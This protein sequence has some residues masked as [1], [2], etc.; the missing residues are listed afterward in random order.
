[1]KHI[2]LAGSW[3]LSKNSE[4]KFIKANLPGDNLSA[5]YQAGEVDDP[6]HGKNELDLQWLGSTKW[7]YSRT[8]TVK[9]STLDELSIMLNIENIDTFA[10]IFINEKKVGS[11][12]NAFRRYRFEVKK[13]L[14]IGENQIKIVFAPHEQILAKKAKK[15]PRP[16]PHTINKVQSMHR[17]L[18]RKTQCHAGWDWGP[19]LMVSGVYGDIHLD[20]TSISRISHVTTTQKFKGDDCIVT[21]TNEVEAVV[22][23]KVPLSIELGGKSVSKMVNL[24][25]GLNNISEKIVIK[26][27]ERWWP[28]GYGKQKLY[29]LLVT[30]AED[31]IEKKL[32]L[33][34]LEIITNEDNKG[35]SLVF[36]VN[37]VDIFCKG[38]NW[39]PVDAMPE[40]Q[41]REVYD[42]LLSSAAEVHMNM[43]RVWGGGQY[44]RDDFYQLC[45]EK[46]LLVWQ[47]FMFACAPYPGDKEFFDNVKIEAEYQIKRLQ[48]HASLAFWCGNNECFV[49][50]P[51]ENRNNYL[52]DYDRLY[53]RLLRNSVESIDPTHKYWPS[54]PSGGRDDYSD[55]FHDDSRGDMHYWGV[56]H[57]GKNFDAYYDIIPRFCSEFGYQSFPS[58]EVIE[59]YADKDQWNVTAPVM[60]HHQKNA[61][62]NSKITEMF[63]RYFRIPQG[64]DNFVYLSQVQQGIAIRTAIEYWRSL[65]PTCMGT[66]YW[67][68]NDN[69]PVCSWSSLNYGGKWKILHYMAKRF[70]APLMLTVFQRKYGAPVE[71]W[72][73]N[74]LLEA[75]TGTMT[76]KVCDFT[77]KVLKKESR[78]IKLAK[79]S[80]KQIINYKVNK[81]TDREDETF[82][83]VELKVGK[84]TIRNDLFFTEYKRCNLPEAKIKTIIGEKEDKLT[85]TLEASA[86]AFF[87]TLDAK[88]LNGE[89]NDNAITLMPGEKRTLIFNS[90]ESISRIALKETLVLRHLRE[91]Y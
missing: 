90:R 21:V 33:R 35:M 76:M 48:N 81:L 8:F 46:G 53:E 15:L 41:T 52:V 39:I 5:L 17:N 71:I 58:P 14:R 29:P 45:D 30:I 1:M 9:D 34:E 78:N 44:E 64:F 51:Q 55:C 6:Y 19:C 16:L 32:G 36:R 73:V 2:D 83:I 82:M 63:S 66:L 68:L 18:A 84:E 77:G 7:I 79:N 31:R 74:D 54:S 47:D 80:S 49:Y 67:Q 42:N 37:G 69:W 27:A 61:N 28:N 59:T 25:Q 56:W 40:R 88:G 72:G 60:E 10:T 87:V 26:N 4:S 11:T 3:K 89:F 38:A 91:T 70:Y 50:F 43:I 12:E 65:R 22:T 23:G 20:A 85:V 62:G 24:K 57:G 86:P 75:Q 13:Y